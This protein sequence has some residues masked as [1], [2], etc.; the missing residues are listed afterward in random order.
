MVQFSIS[1]IDQG[2]GEDKDIDKITNRTEDVEKSNR[3]RTGD[4]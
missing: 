3:K 1:T 2:L 4:D